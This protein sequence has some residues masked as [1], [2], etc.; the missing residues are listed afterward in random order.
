MLNLH[1][2]S[3]PS[4]A[5]RGG[6]AL[7][8]L[9]NAALLALFALQISGNN[10]W[11][12]LAGY[13][14]GAFFVSDRLLQV[15]TWSPLLAP[16]WLWLLRRSGFVISK[17]ALP[18]LLVGLALLGLFFFPALQ[19]NLAAPTPWRQ[20]WTLAWTLGV[21]RTL[22][23]AFFLLG[24]F[25]WLTGVNRAR[26]AQGANARDAID[27]SRIR[28][29]WLIAAFAAVALARY[30]Y[31]GP[32]IPRLEDELAYRLQSFLFLS[33]QLMGAAPAPAGLTQERWND[34][35]LL[36]FMLRDGEWFYS[37]HHH[38]WSAL[39]AV[40]E[41]ARLGGAANAL[42]AVGALAL[43]GPL[44]SAAA[45]ASDRGDR[46]LAVALAASLPALYFA[47][48]SYMSHVA[49]L[50]LECAFALGW[51]L[52]PR[53]AGWLLTFAAGVALAF[54]RPQSAVALMGA[55]LAVDALAA[56][57]ART[58]GA[59]ALAPRRY[60][61]L[62]ALQTAAALVIGLA[63]VRAYGGLFPADRL[64]FTEAFLAEYAAPGCQ[65]L[66]FGADRGCYPTYGTLGHSWRKF[67]LNNLEALQ[68]LSL[69]LALF[70]APT[71]AA[72]VAL[73]WRNPR[74]FRVG[75]A[76]LALLAVLGAHLALFGAYWHNG[77]ES[78][79]GR[80]LLDCAFAPVLLAVLL[81]RA[82]RAGAA[83]YGGALQRFA[84]AASLAMLL[85]NALALARGGFVNVAAPPFRSVNEFS[86]APLSG[87]LIVTAL[88]ANSGPL[89]APDEFEPGLVRTL[90]QRRV[91]AFLNDGYVTLAAAA[92]RFDERGRLRDASE[93][94]LVGPAT[95]A[96]AAIIQADAGAR[97][98]RRL[99]LLPPEFQRSGRGRGAWTPGRFTLESPDLK[100]AQAEM[101]N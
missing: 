74:M 75:G 8:I 29:W 69:D 61:L 2:T 20:L 97:E 86:S 42:L 36:P 100:R 31:E 22:A 21:A 85:L 87:A 26:E 82:D 6:L 11:F 52:Y 59:D 47:S 80:Y 27:A 24:L 68:S 76:P 93:N 81:W 48:G 33:G 28:P 17:R 55:L 38:G 49:A 13:A 84:L 72:L 88:N 77:G 66:G 16:L 30:L 67:L 5:A 44:L 71:L 60:Y 9:T 23:A 64:F 7:I 12:K 39:L 89:R 53:R 101:R 43:I 37:A 32:A 51:F 19:L 99:Q 45:P 46:T 18:A 41:A 92:K 70:G 65:A 90:E 78:Y 62:R 15:L 57:P 95:D 73:A 40:F 94:V 1:T 79:R 14:P 98:I 35:L 34:I 58:A 96:E 91:R 63:L 56:L 3:A 4:R 10:F 83:L 54:V 25:A 50:A